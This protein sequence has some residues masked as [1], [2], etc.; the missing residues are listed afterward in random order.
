MAITK[1]EK[2]INFYHKL[3]LVFL[4]IFPLGQLLRFQVEFFGNVIAV[5]PVDLIAALSVSVIFTRFN[6]TKIKK[7]I[8]PIFASGLFSLVISLNFYSFFNVLHGELYLFRLFSYFCLFLISVLV[9]K[10]KGGAQ[11]IKAIY[12]SLMVTAVLGWLQYL[13]TPDLRWLKDFGWDDHLNRMT[14]TF[15]DP[16]FTGLIFVFG[17]ILSVNKYLAE[18][19]TIYGLSGAFFAISTLLTYSRASYIAMFA[20]LVY[21]FVKFSV[22]LKHIALVF[23]LIFGSILLLPRPGGEGVRLERVASI[24]ARLTDYEFVTGI[25]LENPLFGIGYDNLCWERNAILGI[26][27]TQSHACFGSDSSLLMFLTTFGVV[28][29]TIVVGAANKIHKLIKKSEHNNIF[30]ASLAAVI[31]HSL[32]NNSLFYPWVMGYLA[33][34]LALN[35]Q[36][37]D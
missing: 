2:A 34:L 10:A 18:K 4:V 14:G 1:S 23:I 19:K 5:H 7:I 11:I 28:G 24:N 32:F 27:N 25:F 22:K 20:A 16:G 37:K 8:Y 35:I 36:T 15:L 17:F 3:I 12:L 31:V 30:S 21:L 13:L 33:I 9:V 6:F 26:N 29:T